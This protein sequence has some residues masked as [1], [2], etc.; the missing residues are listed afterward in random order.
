M[1]DND[2]VTVEMVAIINGHEC[3]YWL[4]I[5][6]EMWQHPEIQIGMLKN[7]KHKLLDRA[8]DGLEP[9]VTV[10]E[11]Q[12]GRRILGGVLEGVSGDGG[13]FCTVESR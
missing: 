2:Y 11:Y 5:S 6:R 3:H 10:H 12:D 8:L 4:D 13:Y 1:N 9:R 7:M